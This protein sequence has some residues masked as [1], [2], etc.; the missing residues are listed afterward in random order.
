MNGH[1]RTIGKP[2]WRPITIA[3]EATAAALEQVVNQ[4]ALEELLC[5]LD[6]RK[7][8]GLI[9]FDGEERFACPECQRPPWRPLHSPPAVLVVSD[10]R[11]VCESCDRVLTLHLL[12]R[13]VLEDAEA[14]SRL[15]AEVAS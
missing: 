15:L 14:V 11:A 10:L 13:L 3:P 2:K 4:C 12:R 8:S 6:Q 9:L 7:A 5:A 1:R